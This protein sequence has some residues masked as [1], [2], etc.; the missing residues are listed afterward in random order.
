M[1]L[2]SYRATV[3]CPTV[4]SL[5]AAGAE[6]PKCPTTCC[7]QTRFFGAF[8]ASKPA[9]HAKCF[10]NPSARGTFLSS[11]LERD[12]GF[13]SDGR[14]RSVA[15]S[16][17]G[18]NPV[19]ERFPSLSLPAAVSRISGAMVVQKARVLTRSLPQSRA[20]SLPAPSFFFRPAAFRGNRFA[21]IAA[22]A[23]ALFVEHTHR[24]CSIGNRRYEY[25]Y[26]TSRARGPAS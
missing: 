8:F 20:T 1:Q 26:R 6:P 19:V 2:N 12:R 13:P 24:F 16:G 10:Q 9:N 18:N 17:L 22:F 11:V 5:F 21:S 23:C 7:P 14:R 3:Q 15:I 25:C 4:P